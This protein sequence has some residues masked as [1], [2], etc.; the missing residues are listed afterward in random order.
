MTDADTGAILER[1]SALDSST[2]SDVLDAAGYPGQVLS[3]DIR[4]ID[5]T[6]RMAGRAFCARGD[7]SKTASGVSPYDLEDGIGPG[8]IAVIAT[9]RFK[10][11]AVS[12]GMIALQLQNRGA[13]GL[14]TDGAIRDAAEIIGFGLPVVCGNFTPANSAGRWSIVEIGGVVHL[15]GLD[16]EWV[17]IEPG[18]Y[19]LADMDG[20]VVVPQRH[21]GEIVEATERAM[22]IERKIIGEIKAGSTRQEAFS[23]NPRFAHVPKLRASAL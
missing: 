3:V 8:E 23:R 2:L 21:I 6:R 7:V 18:D 12:G 17:A 13:R 20:T 19:I 9:G 16:T 14:V 1:F 4:L 15:P 5:A 10:A 22:T 11:G